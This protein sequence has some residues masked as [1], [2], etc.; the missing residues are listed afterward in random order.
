M[1]EMRQ[2]SSLFKPFL[3][4]KKSS[5]SF[6][7]PES[8]RNQQKYSQN[9][10]EGKRYQQILR[11]KRHGTHLGLLLGGRFQKKEERQKYAEEKQS[12]RQLLQHLAT[13][14][15]Q[16]ETQVQ[17]P[18]PPLTTSFLNLSFLTLNGRNNLVSWWG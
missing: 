10:T 17:I 8:P 4:L 2:I 9:S 6:Q 11:K 13:D 18:A 16:L 14:I 7:P 1:N 15:L 3:D 12:K 5:N